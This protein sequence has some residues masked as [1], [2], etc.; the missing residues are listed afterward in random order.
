MT[1]LRTHLDRATRS[2]EPTQ[3]R[4]EGILVR[5]R[6]RQR[7]RRLVSGAVGLTV[8]AA[9][10][11]F[12]WT[13]FGPGPR[14]VGDPGCPRRWGTVSAAGEGGLADV[15][16]LSADDVWAV[17]PDDEVGAGSRTVIQRWTGSSWKAVQSPNASIAE[18]S[19][20]FLTG[21]DAI[22]PEDAWAVGMAAESY[23]LHR[24]NPGRSLIEHWD[25]RTWSIVP[26]PSPG[27]FE[28]RLNA[29]AAVSSDDVWAVG[30]RGEGTRAVPMIQHW[31]GT[32]WAIVPGPDVVD[33]T[34][35][36]SLDDVLAFATDDVWAVGSQSSGILIEHWDGSRWSLVEAPD[37]GRHAFLQAVD[38]S[39]RDD[40]WAVGWTM[41]ASIEAEPTPPIV[42]HFDG[43]RW[44]PI[45]LPMPENTY[46]VLRAV[47]VIGPADV[48]VGGWMGESNNS[49]DLEGFRP[50]AAHWDG[51]EWR[52]EDIGV[53]EPGSMV[54]AAATAGEEL[55]LVGRHGGDYTDV[56]ANLRGAQHLTVM[57]TCKS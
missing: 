35:G 48:W 55:W 46:L 7:H 6:R 17:G 3:D 20:N 57:G 22:T 54:S 14:T 52:L 13:S 2:F 38:G 49:E 27:G 53:E 18:G 36:A 19:V 42:L 11:G 21:V 24:G 47:A 5:A 41:S 25:G 30:H 56:H 31:D 16:A 10:S 51:S 34:D 50:L 43:E 28:S 40:V 26:A 23:P 4:F 1:E 32:A 8:F 9:S 29:V 39:S 33:D 15:T 37:L 44:D 45:Q 12:L